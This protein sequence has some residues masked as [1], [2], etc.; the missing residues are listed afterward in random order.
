[1]NEIK[2]FMANNEI[3]QFRDVATTSHQATSQEEAGV[4]IIKCGKKV[5]W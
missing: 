3:M 1:M 5:V 4:P 2:V